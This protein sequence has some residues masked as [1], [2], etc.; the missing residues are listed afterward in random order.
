MKKTLIHVLVLALLLL[1]AAVPAFAGG[2]QVRSN[3][4][5]D[6]PFRCRCKT[7]AVPTVS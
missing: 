1:F 4:A 5:R 6:R 2:D 7:T 3:N